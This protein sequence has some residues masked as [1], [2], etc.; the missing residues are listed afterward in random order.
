MEFETPISHMQRNKGNC[1]TA[2]F[3]V[4]VRHRQK[5]TPHFYRH[6]DSCEQDFKHQ[7]S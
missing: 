3:P 6:H 4:P 5:L 1:A 2:R 7:H